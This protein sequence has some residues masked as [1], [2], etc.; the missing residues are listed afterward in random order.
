MNNQICMLIKEIGRSFDIFDN[1]GLKK[2]DIC[3][4]L[5][6]EMFIANLI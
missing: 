5:K 4:K 3:V 6:K 2:H 1:F